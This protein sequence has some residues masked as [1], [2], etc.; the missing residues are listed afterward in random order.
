MTF[1][2]A[3][4]IKK[5]RRGENHT[6][7]ELAFLVNEFTKGTIPEYQ[8][9]AWLMAVC[10]QGMEDREIASF[11]RS[12]RDSGKV[13]DFSK[14]GR[15][16]IDKH[17]TGGVGDKTSLI[18]GPLAAAAGVSVASIAG[19]GLGHSGG[20]LDKLESIPG[21]SV[22]VTLEKFQEL[23]AE[24]NLALV[25]QTNDVCPA[26]KKL[27]ALRDVTGTVDSL[28]L[29]CG[30]IMSKKLAEGLSGLVL[31]VKFGSGAFMKTFEEAKQLALQLKSIGEH[32]GV[33]V[34]ALLTNMNQPLG[35]AV[36]NSLEVEECLAIMRGEREPHFED[37]RQLCL[38]LAA[39]MIH[40]GGKASDIVMA[41]QLAEELL[42]AGKALHEFTE[43]C[44]RQGA[45]SIGPLAKATI[46]E[47]VVAPKSGYIFAMNTE[48]IGVSSLLLGAGRFSADDQ[49]D[50]A[51]GIECMKKIGDPVQA[52]ECLFRL[53]ANDKNRLTETKTKL[54][55]SVEISSNVPPPQELV[56]EILS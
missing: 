11:T 5:K 48:A 20:T 46:I 37:T 31:D 15:P 38:E 9:S 19:R 50:M 45:P 39:W 33:K 4:L 34:V 13:L 35:R 56:A 17:S 41:R 7:E 21:F 36:G 28:P 22:Q 18:V 52:G 16:V 1:I 26:D 32:N 43:L 24:Y 30:S 8:M 14:L 23:V 55:E 10:F 6:D 40:L 42:V 51:A 3:E 12:M 54:L 47:E 53:H 29:I 2:P 44:R 25:G 27:Y 49:I